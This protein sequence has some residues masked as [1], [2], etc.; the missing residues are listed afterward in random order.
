MGSSGPSGRQGPHRA[1]LKRGDACLY[2]RKRRIR[3]SATK[4]SCH[5]CTKL[6]RVCVY[7]TSK[8]VS[9]VRQLENKVAELEDSLR[10]AHATIQAQLQAQ[11]AAVGAMQVGGG[12]PIM[13]DLLGVGPSTPYPAG[14]DALELSTA[15]IT[16]GSHI[17]PLE[18]SSLQMTP[19]AAHIG[20]L[21]AQRLP[22]VSPTQL[23]HSSPTPSLQPRRGHSYEPSNDL[24][25]SY[26]SFDPGQPTS[27]SL[28]GHGQGH[29]IP[30][31]ATQASYFADQH[32]SYLQS[33]GAQ[34]LGSST[35]LGVSGVGKSNQDQPPSDPP[36]ARSEGAVPQASS[37][38][39]GFAPRVIPVP[40]LGSAATPNSAQQHQHQ[41]RRPF[42]QQAQT[43]SRMSAGTADAMPAAQFLYAGSLEENEGHS[44]SPRNTPGSTPWGST[45]SSVHY[46]HSRP[47]GSHP[48]DESLHANSGWYE[49][50]HQSSGAR[51][52]L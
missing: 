8:P 21:S 31:P 2:C 16:P 13:P 34:P 41:Q 3:C 20:Q 9:R 52:Q 7:D 36:R 25:Q 44:S 38:C 11:T 10:A 27:V 1:P 5:H 29:I 39:E 43:P 4:P 12:M 24:D 32:Y 28:Y 48:N 14:T 49:T 45:P 35:L 47:E 40:D 30:R 15:A 22:M 51:D 23:G 17:H 50:Y 18:E 33:T 46:P 42:R 37:S 6:K 26:F 19:M